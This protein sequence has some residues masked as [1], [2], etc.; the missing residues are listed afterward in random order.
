MVGDTEYMEMY[1]WQYNQVVHNISFKIHSSQI[2]KLSWWF[3][4]VKHSE[5][6]CSVGGGHLIREDYIHEFPS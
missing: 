4:A 1:K 2:L 3:G 6:I 5:K